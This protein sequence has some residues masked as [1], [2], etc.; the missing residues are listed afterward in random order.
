MDDMKLMAL[1]LLWVGIWLNISRTRELEERQMREARKRRERL[2]RRAGYGN[3]AD[4][5]IID[6]FPIPDTY[7]K[8][9]SK[10]KED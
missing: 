10:T 4:V 7:K 2:M 3:R 6:E 8:E 9:S 1:V 5:Q